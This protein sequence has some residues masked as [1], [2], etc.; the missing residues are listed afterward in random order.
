MVDHQRN[1]DERNDR[2]DYGGQKPY[3][4]VQVDA[5]VVGTDSLLCEA[6]IVLMIDEVLTKLGLPDFTIKINNRKILTGIAE[7]IGQADN[8]AVICT[9]IDKIDKIGWEDETGGS[10]AQ[11]K[12]TARINYNEKKEREKA[13]RREKARIAKLEAQIVKSEN[14]LKEYHEQLAVEANRNNL[15]QMN[16]LSKKISQIK[17]EVD[18]LYREYAE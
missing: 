5:D 17:Q 2:G 4:I 1:G 16:D 10:S 7:A 18:N 11:K 12:P 14:V 8:E 15:A 3:G 9:A 6:E 13:E